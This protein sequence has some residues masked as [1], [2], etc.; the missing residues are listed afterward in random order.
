MITYGRAVER[1]Y[2]GVAALDRASWGHDEECAFVADGEHVWRIWAGHAELF[3]AKDGPAVVGAAVAFPC[4]SGKY[5]LHK[6]MVDG[7][8][9]RKRIATALINMILE[10]MDEKRV[11]VFLT[12]NPKNWG[13]VDFYVRLGFSE[14]EFVAGYYREREDRFVL[15]KRF[16]G[17]CR[18]G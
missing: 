5:Y 7:D 13:L 11:D 16:A 12:A 1:D 6:V 2:L 14:K 8:Y 4:V 3:V 18:H 17:N 10:E 9:R 15:T